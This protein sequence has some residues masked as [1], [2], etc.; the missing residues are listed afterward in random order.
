MEEPSLR[1]A[2]NNG[3]DDEELDYPKEASTGS[4]GEASRVLLENGGLK[5]EPTGPGQAMADEEDAAEGPA[6]GACVPKRGKNGCGCGCGCG[7]GL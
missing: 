4:D 2:L 5:N 1:I 6:L 3:G 7:D